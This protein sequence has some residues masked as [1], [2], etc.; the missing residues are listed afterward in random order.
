MRVFPVHVFIAL[1]LVCAVALFFQK[2]MAQNLAYHQ[3]ADGRTMLGIPNFWNVVSN[4]P[5]FFV[6][7]YGLFRC[8]SMWKLRS[9][10]T[11]RLIPLILGIGVFSVS[12][13][14]AYYH[15]APSNATLIWDRLPM[16]LMFMAL[17]S[18]VLFD[19]LGEK[20]GEIGLWVSVPFGIFS[21]VYWH[22][23]EIVGQGD[24]R[25]Y[26]FVQFFPMVAV[27]ALVLFFPK[28]VKYGG[29]LLGIVGIYGVA[30]AAEHLDFEI[31]RM[32]GFWSG[33]TIKHLVGA[34]SLFFAMK[35]LDGWKVT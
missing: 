20:W 28:R 9:S 5:F 22:F 23:T 11:M 30:K 34:A 21:V 10:G 14:S 19:F 31:F 27:I 7:S 18:L 29:L 16:T 12:F 4:L 25:P 35:I 32:L 24:L 15:A 8:F 1:F 26:A 3:F 17:F 6:G 33:H 2:P 13:G